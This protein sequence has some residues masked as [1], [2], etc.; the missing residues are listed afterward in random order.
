MKKSSPNSIISFSHSDKLS[1]PEENEEDEDTDDTTARSFT[2]NHV[3]KV[4]ARFLDMANVTSSRVFL[5]R[6]LYGSQKIETICSATQTEEIQS[7]H[8]PYEYLFLDVFPP[9]HPTSAIDHVSPTESDNSLDERQPSVYEK[10]YAPSKLLQKYID[11][12]VYCH[13]EKTPFS[14]RLGYCKYDFTLKRILRCKNLI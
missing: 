7:F 14:E 8:F 4:V 2:E 1:L 12:A 5:N 9:L 13:T 6:Y 11:A 3:S 10:M